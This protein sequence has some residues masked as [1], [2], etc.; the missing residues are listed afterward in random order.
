MVSQGK[1]VVLVL[2]AL[3]YLKYCDQI[4]FLEKGVAMTV[5]TY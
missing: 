2:N 3:Q 4:V 5:G 1:T